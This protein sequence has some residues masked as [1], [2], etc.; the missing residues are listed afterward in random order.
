M[1]DVIELV[2]L[3]DGEHTCGEIHSDK[4]LRGGADTH[5]DM[6]TIVK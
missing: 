1:D 3:D 5:I 2:H 4:I 6:T